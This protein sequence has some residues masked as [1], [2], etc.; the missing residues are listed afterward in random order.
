M[1][2]D[3][4]SNAVKDLN[5]ENIVHFPTTFPEVFL[6]EKSGFDAIIGNP[7]WEEATIERH[8]FW[9]RYFPGLRGM[10]QRVRESK[11]EEY[12]KNYPELQSE[13]ELKQKENEILR[14]NLIS[15]PFPGMGTGDP[16]LY[17]AFCWRFWNLC[18]VDDGFIGV[19]VPR[20]V[21]NSKGSSI[22]RKTI[23][24]ESKSLG[25]VTLLN[26]V[27]WV[28]DIHAQ[29]IIV[30]LTIE[31]GNNIDTKVKIRGHYES[32]EKFNSGINSKVDPFLG[33]D[34]LAYTEDALFPS[35]PSPESSS[36][37]MKLFESPAINS[38]ENHSWEIYPHS[39]LHATND[40]KD[41]SSGIELMDLTSESCPEG[42]WPVY[43]GVSFDH[44]KIDSGE[45]YAWSDPK[46]VLP[47]LQQKRIR[48]MNNRKS[49][50]SKF[51]P[52]WNH[53]E[54]TLPCLNPRIAFRDITNS[55]DSRS[56]I[57]AL[58][59]P[60]NF[61]T[62]KAPYLLFPKGNEQQITY[63]LGI[64]SS[65]S[66]DWWARRFIGLN[67]NFFIFNSFPI[68]IYDESSKL[69]KRL[70]ELTGL[71]SC[72]DNRFQK[73]AN[74]LGIEVTALDSDQREQFLYELDAIAAH[75]YG[76]TEDQLIH[77]FKTYRLN[78]D[79]SL[80]LENTLKFYHQYS[81]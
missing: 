81:H 35:L 22:F 63:V 9:A 10:S 13:L 37:M 61:L 23:L 68:P 57:C 75:L 49:A 60:N 77:I 58:I 52:E 24:S 62:N 30:L 74:I 12:V 43:K 1:K 17:K 76:L 44:L 27:K 42:Y 47:Y 2:S 41:K 8:A 28:F 4:R 18:N 65:I 67:L 66:L 40:K 54:A 32:L 19:V 56:V 50:F 26:T 3:A 59:P 80:R 16:D 36:L 71:L 21:I 70:V 31:R 64:L 33:K 69:S 55:L 79:Y 5:T 25:A 72:V 73:W 6:R 38:K 15:G 11:I 53:N 48:S 51:N 46:K 14:K 34:I 78:W 29:Y 45:Y 39:E 20:S 7:P